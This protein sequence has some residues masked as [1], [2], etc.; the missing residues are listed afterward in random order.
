MHVTTDW[1]P[2][3]IWALGHLGR[4]H[5]ILDDEIRTTLYPLTQGQP[6]KELHPWRHPASPD[7]TK[8]LHP[9]PSPHRA[10]LDRTCLTEVC[11]L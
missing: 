8:Q 4:R 1:A 11:C 2:G 6:T 3:R 10:A 5:H 7:E 9:R